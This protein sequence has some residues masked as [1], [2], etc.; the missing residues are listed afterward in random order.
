MNIVDIVVLGFAALALASGYR[1]GLVLTVGQYVG[2]IAGLVAGASL[3]PTVVDW[4]GV[5]AI[6]ARILI[7]VLVVMVA[8][9]VGHRLGDAVASP[10][11]HAL[12]RLPFAAMLDHAGGAAVSLVIALVVAWAAARTLANGPGQPARLIQQSVVV[13]QLD[14][15]A[16]PAPGLLTSLQRVL[17]DELGPNVFIGLEP[18]LPSALA[19]DPSSAATPAVAN[20]ARSVVRIEGTGCG[21]RVSGSGFPIAPDEVITNAHVVAG[22]RQTTVVT[23]RGR[24]PGQVVLF[25]PERD[26][27]VVRAPGL[28]LAPLSFGDAPR[29]RRGAVIGYPGGGPER[30]APSVID[31]RISARGEDIFGDNGVTRDVLVVGADIRPGDSGGPVVDSNGLVLGVIFARSVAH[32]GQGFALT[33]KE[34]ATD[35]QSLDSGQPILDAGRR[36]QCASS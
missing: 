17:T 1:Q 13:R 6:P 29:G 21:G 36:F 16:P 15:L 20:V 28:N 8:A 26:V 5:A 34:I 27:A 2:V 25:D 35:L 14:A 4:T 3:A 22:T 11:S 33:A 31:G 18:Q 32:P 10:F 24:F 19:L 12:G 9:T 7:V 30:V 23:G